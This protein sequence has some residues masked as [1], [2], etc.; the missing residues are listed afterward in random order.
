M[1]IR[2]AEIDDARAI[3][4]IHVESWQNAYRDVLPEEGL[5]ALSVEE[6]TQYWKERLEAQS[7][8]E[9]TLVA[10]LDNRVVGFA[11]WGP[12][13]VED[14]DPSYVMLY[15]LY[16]SPDFEKQ[17]VGA[18]LLEA[19]EVDMIT[20][21][22]VHGILHVLKENRTARKLYERNGWQ[23]VEKSS[24]EETWFGMSMTTVQF[25]KAFS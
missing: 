2:P 6:R 21:G 18:A 20:E 5:E 19:A 7:E 1:I 12:E 13:S 23:K 14:P 17:G 8:H 9:H 3:A 15:S 4:T 24:R 16:T 22:A 25:E 11:S 10:E